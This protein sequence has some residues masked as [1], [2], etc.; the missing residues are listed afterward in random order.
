VAAYYIA[1]EALTNATKHARATVVNLDLE[2]EDAGI[3]LTI[4]D[5]GVGGAVLGHG[6]GLIGVRDR[7]EALGGTVEIDSPAG[8]GRRYS[9]GLRSS[10]QLGRLAPRFRR[11]R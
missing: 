8:R 5:D 6:S 1:S 2:P 7:V 11:S 10:D 3:E 9:S 4:P